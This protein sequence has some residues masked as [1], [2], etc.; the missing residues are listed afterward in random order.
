MDNKEKMLS[1]IEKLQKDVE[2]L[3]N[4]VQSLTA[5]GNQGNFKTIVRSTEKT[6][7]AVLNG[8]IDTI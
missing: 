4:E 7:S 6:G 8:D 5:E 2:E 3:R 1:S